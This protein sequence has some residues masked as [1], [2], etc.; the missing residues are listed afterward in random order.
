M[1]QLLL[2]KHTAIICKTN[3][4]NK[5]SSH[6]YSFHFRNKTRKID[7]V[8]QPPVGHFQNN[9]QNQTRNNM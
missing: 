3:W 5:L 7:D 6:N 8:F 4:V 2:F 9:L 1:I